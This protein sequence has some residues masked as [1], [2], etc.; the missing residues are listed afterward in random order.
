[1]LENPWL[2]VALLSAPGLAPV[3]IHHL[4]LSNLTT[5][6]QPVSKEL[7]KITSLSSALAQ[8]SSLSDIDLSPCCASLQPMSQQR[9]DAAGTDFMHVMSVHIPDLCIHRRATVKKLS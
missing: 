6:R 9:A 1:M 5:V 2:A 8:Q 3:G 7:I 4:L